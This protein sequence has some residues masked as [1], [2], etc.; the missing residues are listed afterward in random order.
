MYRLA[1]IE[2]S[3][4]SVYK[5]TLPPPKENQKLYLVTAKKDQKDWH[6]YRRLNKDIIIVSTEAI[7]SAVMRQTCE[8][9]TSYSLA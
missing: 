3:G 8:R 4:G 2:A 5:N 9:M 6:K 1:I 7:M